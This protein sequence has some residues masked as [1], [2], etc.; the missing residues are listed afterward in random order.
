MLKLRSALVAAAVAVSVVTG[1]AA[2]EAAPAVTIQKIPAK[3]IAANTSTVI[4]PK[5]TR[6][7]RVSIGSKTIT[8]KAGSK[9]LVD[10]KA[11]ARLKAGTYRVTTRVQFATWQMCDGVRKYSQLREVSK[12]QTLQIKTKAKAAPK[13]KPSASQPCTTTSSGTCI[14]GGQFCPQ[15]RYGQSGFDANGRRYVCTGDRTHPHW[16]TP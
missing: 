10:R 1:V 14:R 4:T 7:S 6:S 13:P 15:A 16:M 5:I 2:A 12:T 3:T 9:T 8:V 11:S